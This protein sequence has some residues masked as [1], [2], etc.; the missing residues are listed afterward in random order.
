MVLLPVGVVMG[1]GRVGRGF[2][3]EGG[4]GGWVVGRW[5]GGEQQQQQ[6]RQRPNL[7]IQLVLVILNPPLSS[8]SLSYIPYPLSPI[9]YAL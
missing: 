8:S 9:A 3:G 7:F 5:W 1:W 6:Q 2:R 4:C